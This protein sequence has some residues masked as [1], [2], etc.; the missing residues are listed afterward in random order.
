MNVP[1]DQ[2]Q[3]LDFHRLSKERLHADF[4]RVTAIV[5][6]FLTEKEQLLLQEDFDFYLEDT[7]RVYVHNTFAGGIIFLREPEIIEGIKIEFNS[8]RNEAWASVE[9]A[10]ELR[11][12][13]N[14]KYKPDAGKIEK[15]NWN[16]LAIFPNFTKH[17]R[18]IQVI[19]MIIIGKIVKHICEY[20]KSN[21]WF[22]EF[23]KAFE[24]QLFLDGDLELEYPVEIFEQER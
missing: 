24:I 23:E 19:L 18:D 3:E 8:T 17:R 12:S 20:Y 10:S 2:I 16:M 1:L 14:V 11:N 7:G 21:S 5:F 15:V 13:R 22:M 9:Y 4:N 6:P